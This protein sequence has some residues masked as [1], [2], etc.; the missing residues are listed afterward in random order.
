MLRLGSLSLDAPCVQA[1]L[2]GYSDWPM[3]AMARQFGAPYTIHEVMLDRFAREVG[4]TGRT[5][6]HLRVTDN[7]HP[8]GAQLMGSV[9]AD[10]GPAAQR[11]MEAGFD[12][13][14]IN[15]GC[16][17]R[18]AVGG[19][20]GGYHLSQPE[21]AI[22]II[23]RV[24]DSLPTRVP[25]TVKMRRGLDDS[26]LSRD[27]FFTIL[28]GAFDAG[29]AAVT[30]HPRTVEQKYVGPSRWSF[31]RE[32]KQHAGQRVVVGSGDLFSAPDC[33][34][35]LHET[36]V[37]GVS[38]ARGAI[39]NP[40]IF[41]QCRA[42]LAGE[43]LPLPPSVADQRIALVR[44]WKLA[45]STYAGRAINTMRKFAIKYAR[46]H[47]QYVE[48][49]NAFAA[50]RTA[51]EWEQVLAVWYTDDRPGQYPQPDEIRSATTANDVE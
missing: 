20:R 38:I 12:V 16:P 3:R 8:V 28:D 50:V 46:S 22:E 6:H 25:V 51:A 30:I 5:E 49:R 36:G 24:R 18:S 43:A 45:V 40:W 32:V 34:R 11:L 4:G 48:V 15:F 7:D 10:F 1:A 31:L 44:H 2:S 39:G 21:I 14:D 33:L 29:A 47:P 27:R 26:P 41:S 42:L 17:V 23:R 19:C 9:P 37:D 35:M 13:I